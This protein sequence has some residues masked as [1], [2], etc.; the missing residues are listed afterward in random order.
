MRRALITGI[1]GQ[2]GY[3]LAKH[4]LEKNYEVFGTMRRTPFA[5]SEILSILPKENFLF[6]DMRNSSQLYEAVIKV[7][8]DEIYNLAGQTFPPASWHSIPEMMDVNMGGFARILEIISAL[9]YEVRVFQASTADMFGPVE[10]PCNEKTMMHP[11][12]PYGVSKL[13]AHELARLYRQKG[14][15]ISTCILFNHDSPLRGQGFVTRKIVDHIVKHFVLGEPEVLSLGYLDGR[16]DWGYAADYVEAMYMSLRSKPD[17]YVVGTGEAHSV[18]E[19]IFCVLDLL[20]INK[21]LFFKR[22]VKSDESLCRPNETQM[23]CADISKITNELGWQPRHDFYKMI[24]IMV[25]DKL[26]RA[27]DERKN[28]AMSGV[29]KQ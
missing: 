8:P 27:E 7:H 15:F 9:K 17:D 6:A 23:M 11:G 21:E 1:N 14:L 3:Y 20:K 22:W 13:A 5:G 18:R 4:L 12:T 16:R 24:D 2:D 28:K 25:Q 26:R 29:C 19:F 10:G